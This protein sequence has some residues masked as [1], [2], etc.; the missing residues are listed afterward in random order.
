MPLPL[1]NPRALFSKNRRALFSMLVNGQGHSRALFSILNN[2]LG[3][4]QF[5]GIQGHPRALF[6]SC[7]K[8]PT[9]SALFDTGRLLIFGKFSPQDESG[10][11]RN[12]K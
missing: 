6:S 11:L 10:E 5:K 7:R 9:R 12:N 3:I 1:G 4:G 8:I 2:A